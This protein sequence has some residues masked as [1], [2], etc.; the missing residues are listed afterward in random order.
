MKKFLENNP[1]V[2]Y[3]IVLTIVAIACGLLIGGINAWTNPIIKAN[4]QAK[5]DA[6]YQ[7]ALPEG[8]TFADLSM[9]NDPSTIQAK[10][11]GLDANGQVVGYVITANA[12]NVRGN[13]QVV[14]A[15][16]LDGKIVSATFLQLNQ[17]PSYQPPSV[18]NLALY[19]GNDVS[20]QNYDFVSGATV[21]LTTLK[22]VMVDVATAYN[23]I[24]GVGA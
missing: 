16:G 12:T 23:N 7:Q 13:I 22:S 11:E 20:Q 18:S 1:L 2:H 6:S 15:I 24:E 4:E 5:I 10:V 9:A 14:V 17:T 21:S 3:T 8:V 19:V